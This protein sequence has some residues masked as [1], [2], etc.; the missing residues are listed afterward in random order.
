MR[1]IGPN[2]LY[3][4]RTS[5]TLSDKKVWYEVNAASGRDMIIVGS[6]TLTLALVFDAYG[7]D[8]DTSSLIMGAVIILGA[9]LIAF[10]AL[11]RCRTAQRRGGGPSG[12]SPLS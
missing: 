7:M 5:V 1:R 12:P 2:R 4:V 11:S 10:A 8:G 6:L 9:A 3:G